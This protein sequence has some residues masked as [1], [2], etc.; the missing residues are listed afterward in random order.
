MRYC[1][2][3]RHGVHCGAG[4]VRLPATENRRQRIVLHPSSHFF[5]YACCEGLS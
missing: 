1:G 3:H 4:G 2:W 5:C